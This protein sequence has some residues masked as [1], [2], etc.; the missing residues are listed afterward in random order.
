MLDCHCKITRIGAQ[1]VG[2]MDK[3]RIIDTNR[4]HNYIDFAGFG[5][6]LKSSQQFGGYFARDP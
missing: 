1:T 6:M 4:K 3:L 2:W 5:F